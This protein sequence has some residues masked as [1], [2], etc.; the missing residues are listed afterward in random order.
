MQESTIICVDD[1][2]SVLVT[3]KEQLKHHFKD[4]FF[5]EV[6]ESGEEALQILEELTA[7][8]IDVP[9]LISDQIMP[10]IK[11]DE[12]LR[13]VHAFLPKTLTILLTG[14][15]S[16]ADVGNAVNQ[17]RLYRYIG[18]PWEE[19]D[20]VI[21]VKEAVRSYFR[22][23]DLE[24]KNRELESLNRAL[25]IR[26]ERYDRAVKAGG[27]GVWE[28]DPDTDEMYLGANLK[29]LLGYGDHEVQDTMSAWADLFHPDD[30]RAVIAALN[31]CLI[32]ESNGYE[33]EHRMI[34]KDGSVRWFIVRGAA[35]C[36]ATGNPFRMVGAGTD[37]TA[38]KILEEN[39]RK[40][41]F[42]A[43]AAGEFMTLIDRNYV[44][45]AANNAYCDAHGK[46]PNEIVGKTVA[47]IWGREKFENTIKA[48]LEKCFEGNSVNYEAWF[49]FKSNEKR[50]YSVNYYPYFDAKGKV[51]LA[52]VI[53]HNI[54]DRRRMEDDLRAKS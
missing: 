40:Y 8:Q 52:A 54:T 5:I 32:G 42:I 23:K 49:E 43:N 37:I 15:A 47:D 34:H 4:D 27:V 46:S 48:Y 36:D 11:G 53:S 16:A 17:A 21:T 29:A 10:G 3:L 25:R 45:T 51:I 50:F 38:R 9:V 7:E 33:I 35:L 26:D 2:E 6:A 22:D 44:Y 18:K 1:D 13:K 28:W 12:L 14:Q 20:L 19:V 30:K 31:A 39:W 24:A 41:E